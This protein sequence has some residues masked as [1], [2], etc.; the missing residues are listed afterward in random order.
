MAA[1]LNVPGFT[2]TVNTTVS[3]GFS[4]RSSERNCKLQDGYTYNVD[5]TQL[6]AAGQLL[7]A[8]ETV[9]T[10]AQILSGF[11]KN[12]E[13]SG[14][15]AGFRTDAY[16]N[17]STNVI[18]LGS[19]NSDN[20]N[21]NF[22]QGDVIDATQKVFTEIS[23]RTDGGVGVG[24]SFIGSY[25]P[26][27]DFSS[28]N[29]KKLTSAAADELESDVQLLDAYITTSFDAGEGLGFIDVTAGRYVTSWGEA[30]FIPVG[31]NGL[32]TNALDLTKLRA[33]GASIR[34]ALLPTEQ[35]TVGFNAG[36]VGFEVYTQFNAESVTLDPKGSFFGN[37]VSGTGGDRIL[38][39]GAYANEIGDEAYCPA[40]MVIL[41]GATC[42]AALKALTLAPATRHLN[43]DAY[44][45]QQG[46]R[47]ATASQWA[48]WSGLGATIDH[49]KAFQSLA[50]ANPLLG[51][52]QF[53]EVS[54]TLA[55]FSTSLA[56]SSLLPT[57]YGGTK[58]ADF[59]KAATVELLQWDQKEA[60]AKDDGQWGVRAST[61][62]DNVGTG[63]DLGFYYANYHSKVPYIQMMGKT[64]VLAGD[65]IG[66]FTHIFYDF[67]GESETIPAS[68]GSAMV[69][70]NAVNTGDGAAAAT[71]ILIPLINGA[72]GSGVCGG[73]GA[74]L[75]NSAVEGDVDGQFSKK[76][77]ANVK[78]NTLIDGELVH[79]P[80]TCV[81]GNT[82]GV[83]SY[84]PIFLSLTPTLAAA[85]T[86]LNFARYQF[87]YPEDNTVMGMSFST[88][89]EGTVVQGEVAY[90]P[91]FPLATS[92]GDQINQIADASGTT[93]ALTAFGHDTYALA[94]DNVVPGL[95]IP[96]A[97]DALAAGS[98]ISKD[99]G[100]L[101]KASKRSSLPRIDA[102]LVKVY[103]ATSYYRSSAFIEYDTLSVDLGTTTSFA[104]SHPITK[105]LGADSAVL[106][107]ELAM[108]QINDLDNMTNG[109]VARGG[110][111]E[112]SGEHLCL[113][114]FGGLTGTELAA[115]NAQLTSLDGQIDNDMSAIA[116]ATNVGASIVDAIFGNGSYCEGQMGADNRAYSYRVVGSARYDNF[117]NSQWSLSPS[118]NW[119][120]DPKGYG[121]SSLG[122]FTEGRQSISLSLSANRGDGLSTSISYIDQ[123]GD[124]ESNLR[125]DMDYVSASV[126]YAF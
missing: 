84:Q 59:T 50:D 109:F 22:D 10:D 76:V 39:S 98:V 45:S 44:N 46:Y 15:C 48:T 40:S 73:L 80:S 66:A 11:D 99:F 97:V 23:G 70:D 107:T 53:T 57:V 17:T 110:F 13:F 6:S 69:L 42:N 36:N 26:V 51:G 49:G 21:I 78:Y 29:F 27:L 4:V 41:Q 91:D 52:A 105:G 108:V 12:A 79:D 75:A 82:L 19:V 63:V 120:H 104:A 74:T 106:L 126:S 77:I 125:N 3:S 100:T 18:E 58:D 122:G 65:I 43:N 83:T 89:V 16:G 30:T 67:A 20:G 32:V 102:D 31:L 121:P 54:D 93:L 103:D 115:V 7:V 1:D 123:L 85:V 35:L 37:D 87:I 34:D 92:A 90:R 124:D 68:F 71:N 28:E 5:K 114:I 111:N 101:L 61:Y 24:L 33:P 8:S 64:G 96:G 55:A 9:L 56:N 112:G 94:P 81:A 118:I 60:A 117:N 116:G 86:P 38:A 72:Y 119:S 25:N 95:T 47:N 62:L 14:S 113:G 2:G 88:N